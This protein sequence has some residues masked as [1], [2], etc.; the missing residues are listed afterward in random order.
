M[1]I[2]TTVELDI[3]GELEKAWGVVTGVEQAV[4]KDA[5]ILWGDAGG[6]LKALAPT[7][8]VVLKGFVRRALAD[9]ASGDEADLETA[10]LN[11]ASQAEAA[12]VAGLGKLLPVFIALIKAL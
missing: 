12:F 8:Y 6:I 3:E 5:G 7:E 1:S 2:L 11:L 10:V 9:I 4:V